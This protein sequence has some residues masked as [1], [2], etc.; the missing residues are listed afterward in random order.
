MLS[1]EPFAGASEWGLSRRPFAGAS[2]DPA[3]KARSRTKRSKGA[4]KD[5]AHEP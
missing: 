2:E 5:P 4:V 1:A 3:P